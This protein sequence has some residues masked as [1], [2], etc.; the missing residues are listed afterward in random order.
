[1]AAVGLSSVVLVIRRL[2]RT[3]MTCPIVACASAFLKPGSCVETANAGDDVV[4]VPAGG[5]HVLRTV[6]SVA[7]NV[8]SFGGRGIG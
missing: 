5:Q 3:L 2:I 6:I 4:S 8:G 7:Q 1:M